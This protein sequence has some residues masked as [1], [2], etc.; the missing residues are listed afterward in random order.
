[1]QQVDKAIIEFL[2]SNIRSIPDFPKPGILFKDITPLLKNSDTLELTSQMLIRPFRKS[3]VEYIIGLESRGF[4][5]GTGMAQGLNAGFIPVRKPNKL[6]AETI[7]ESYALEYGTDSV[8]IH[9]DALHNGAKVIIHDDLIATGGT[10]LAAYKLASKLG[11]E[12]IG[13]S[14]V[15]ELTALKGRNLLPPGIPIESIIKVT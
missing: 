4:L 3:G 8:E 13:F 11:A 9:K 6:P 7:S 14:F 1:M 15:M 10:A 12:V 5:F 2:E